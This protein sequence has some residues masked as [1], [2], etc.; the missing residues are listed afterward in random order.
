VAKCHDLCVPG[1][2][3]NE[4][5]EVALDQYGFVTTADA[6][7]IG[8]DPQRLVEMAARG[9]AERVFNGIYRLPV[10]GAGALDQLMLATLWPRGLGVLSH[11]TALDLHDL[12]DVNPAKVHVSVPMSYRVTR[13]VPPVYEI[14]RR[15][16]DP[17]VVTRHEA[18]PIVTPARAILDGIE[19]HLRAG[20][21][22]QA[23][24]TGEGRGL[25]AADDLQRIAAA[26]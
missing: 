18:I 25:L 6:R 17:A 7:E 15:R 3:Y 1:R 13:E 11:E 4:L 9:T 12:C 14:H 8:V 10:V 21:I 23:I 16:L 20:L 22:D 2:V 24:E 19:V 5:A 26:R